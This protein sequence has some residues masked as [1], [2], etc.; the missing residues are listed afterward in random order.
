MA[1]DEFTWPAYD[2]PLVHITGMSNEALLTSLLKRL[3]L[4]LN[5]IINFRLEP[6]VG[7][8]RYSNSHGKL[9]LTFN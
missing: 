7:N 8:L 9:L 6:L 1:L 3:I 5:L 2:T 4:V